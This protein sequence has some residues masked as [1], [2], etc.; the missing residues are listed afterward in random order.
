VQA[1]WEWCE[2]KE[3]M[4]L[5]SDEIYAGSVYRETA[6]GQP[7]W[8][9]LACIAARQGRSLGDRA[10]IVWALSKDFALS[11]MRVGALYT[12]NE[13]I[14]VPLQKLN[15]LAQVSSTTQALV[16]RLLSDLEEKTPAQR[17]ADAF[18]PTWAQATQEENCRRLDARYQ[19]LTSVLDEVRI[20]YLPAGAGL[21]IWLDLRA[22]L[23]YS[24]GAPRRAPMASDVTAVTVSE[25]LLDARDAEI[26]RKLYLRLIHEFGLLLT[27][28]ASMRTEAPG[29]FRCVFSAANEQAFEVALQR[30]R[31]FG[32][33][34]RFS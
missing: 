7:P 28:G 16:G 27:P 31:K 9:S 20:P 22:W 17:G 4:H 24:G 3:D 21:F 13:A 29:Y 12:E 1:C 23:D 15:D 26:E 25:A 19:R 14:R 2:G 30:F 32:N 8:T 11:G 33:S 5:V 10:H 34:P 6:E 18:T